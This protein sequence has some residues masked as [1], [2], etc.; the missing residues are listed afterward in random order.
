MLRLKHLVL[1]TR[2]VAT[3]G[4]EHGAWWVL[5][6]FPAILLAMAVVGAAHAAVPYAVYTLF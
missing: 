1:L 3:Y 5:L 2:E 6:V 4:A